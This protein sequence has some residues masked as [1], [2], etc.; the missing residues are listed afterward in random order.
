MT[1]TGPLAVLG[2]VCASVTLGATSYLWHVP[3]GDHWVAPS[4]CNLKGP[5]MPMVLE[6]Q[7]MLVYT[8]TDDQVIVREFAKNYR[9][10]PPLPV[11]PAPVNCAHIPGFVAGI[12]GGCV[13]PDHPHAKK[14]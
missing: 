8:C 4:P 5:A 1:R 14:D 10:P 7:P 3:T 2:I 9:Q 6:G 13:P 11:M 12:Y